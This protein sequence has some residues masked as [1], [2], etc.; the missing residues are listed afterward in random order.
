MLQG[1]RILAN[2]VEC[3]LL[4]YIFSTGDKRTK[5]DT[6]RNLKENTARDMGEGM[7]SPIHIF[8][9]VFSLHVTVCLKYTDT[10][11]NGKN[12]RLCTISFYTKYLQTIGLL[13]NY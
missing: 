1:I 12:R 6:S 7:W 4:H 2:L 11:Y 5:E 13:A 9:D 8:T 3:R 10:G